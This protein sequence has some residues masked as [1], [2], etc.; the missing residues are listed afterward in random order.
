[1]IRICPTPNK[2]IEIDN[3]THDSTGL[4]TKIT[5]ISHQ[6][7]AGSANA[8]FDKTQ[9]FFRHPVAYVGSF[10]H[11]VFA[12]VY[13]WAFVCVFK[14]TK[15][16]KVLAPQWHTWMLFKGNKYL[17][18]NYNFNLQ[19]LYPWLFDQQTATG[20]L[21]LYSSPVFLRIW[22]HDQTSGAFL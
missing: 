16:D 6:P 4:A 5:S 21:C 22:R 13:V 11:F 10:E 17:F 9:F 7:P 19:K 3:S 2:S 18:I 20:D 15:S 8:Q 12:F 14:W 1:M